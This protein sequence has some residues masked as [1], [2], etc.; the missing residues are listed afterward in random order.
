MSDES[1]TVE[2]TFEPEK[3]YVVKDLET[4]K[5]I[6]DTTRIRLL[7][8]LVEKAS[9]VKELARALDLTPTKLYYHINLLEEHGLIRV[10]GTRI[11]SGIIEKQ[12]RT[13]AYSIDIDRSLLALGTEGSDA[14]LDKMLSVIFDATREDMRDALKEGLMELGEEDPKKRKSLVFRTVTKLTPD[15]AR[16]FQERLLEV[17]K[18]FS[19]IN[20]DLKGNE[21]EDCR[22]YGLTVAFFPSVRLDAG[23]SAEQTSSG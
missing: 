4:L 15:Q 17:I 3:Q 10:V 7:E 18:E 8:M 21:P 1:Q 5:V 2:E 16:N 20:D 13:L 11:V 6:S 12:Y 23:R 22:V 9:T 14:A 19:T